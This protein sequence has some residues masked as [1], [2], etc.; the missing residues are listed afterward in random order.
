MLPLE[1]EPTCFRCLSWRCDLPAETDLDR[2][3]ALLLQQGWQV[4]SGVALLRI[5][6]FG[7]NEVSIVPRTGRVLIRVNALV[8]ELERRIA[9]ESMAVFLERAL[10]TM[11]HNPR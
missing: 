5:F 2:L 7:L 6:T 4:N 10:D 3:Q 9:A 1:R 8:P 11:S